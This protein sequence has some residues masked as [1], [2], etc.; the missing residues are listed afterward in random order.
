M[1]SRLHLGL[2]AWPLAALAAWGCGA[3]EDITPENA[4]LR[5]DG[6]A[7]TEVQ[8][9]T[10]RQF[11]AGVNEVGVTQVR[12]FLADTVVQ[13]LPVDM[14]VD[15]SVEQRLYVELLPVGVDRVTVQVRVDVDDRSQVNESGDIV[16]VEPWRFVY[17]FNQ[18]T[19]R[20][21][22]VVL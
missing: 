10:S 1:K 22:D 2:L 15:I 20:I 21:I 6:P 11:V 4:F 7:G 12:V 18:V 13:T 9:V 16:D 17:L 3:F 8:V 14:V 5:V 19:T